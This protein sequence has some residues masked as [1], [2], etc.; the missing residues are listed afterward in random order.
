MRTL[1][2]NG[3]HWL[4]GALLVGS[5]FL[6]PAMRAVLPTW[7][8]PQVSFVTL[9]LGLIWVGL[10]AAHRMHLLHDRL[11]VLEDRAERTERKVEGLEDD[12]RASAGRRARG[13]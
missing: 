11:R 2:E 5:S 3:F 10:F 7:R 4:M 13:P 6:D 1:G 9:V 12:A 8:P